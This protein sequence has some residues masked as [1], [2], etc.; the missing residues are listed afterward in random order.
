M[1]IRKFFNNL[2][3]KNK[4][5]LNAGTI[6]FIIILVMSIVSI[7]EYSALTRKNIIE[8]I[9][10][11]ISYVSKTIDTQI[12]SYKRVLLSMYIDESFHKIITDDDTRY[13]QK[14][15]YWYKKLPLINSYIVS[16]ISGLTYHPDLFI[17]LVPDYQQFDLSYGQVGS[18][19]AIENEEWYNKAVN[20]KNFKILWDVVNSQDENGKIKNILTATIAVRDFSTAA[21]NRIAYA[22]LSQDFRWLDEFLEKTLDLNMGVL[23]IVDKDGEVIYSSESESTTND[24]CELLLWLK[25][26]GHYHDSS[27]YQE[28]KSGGVMKLIYFY[29]N[30]KMDWQILYLTSNDILQ[31]NTYILEKF[32]PYVIIPVLLLSLLLL[33]VSSKIQSDRIIKLKNAVE[34]I[35]GEQLELNANLSGEDEVGVLAESFNKVLGMVRNLIIQNRIIEREKY[36]AELNALQERTNPHFLSNALSSV[37]LMA[38][39]IDAYDISEALAC[40][41]DFYR[42]SLNNEDFITIGEELKMLQLY[43]DICRL[44]FGDQIK[45]S[46]N[47]PDEL[48]SFYTPKLILQPFLENSIIHGFSSDYNREKLI[49]IIAVA[50]DGKV[51]FRIED[52]GTGMDEKMLQR[53]TE[54]QQPDKKYHAIKNTDKRIKL[55]FGEEYGLELKSATGIGTTVTIKIPLM[56]HPNNSSGKSQYKT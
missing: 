10:Q 40:I 26:Y 36:I 17:Y 16:L 5:I 13:N 18:T 42:L 31:N 23:Y 56:T 45:I 52:N 33:F 32:I 44:R 9:N 24:I 55:H 35:N 30:I 48:L 27:G 22:H 15:E 7:S 34:K 49:N 2:Q 20:N 51:I 53:I 11:Q 39:D 21:H 6:L 37:S 38:A 1:W 3:A 29:Y 47:I 46:I 19:T 4:F 43:I 41:A 8:A 14:L 28:I 54:D 25:Y 50:T 12:N